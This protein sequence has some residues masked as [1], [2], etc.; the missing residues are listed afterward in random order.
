MAKRK[1]KKKRFFIITNLVIFITIL[2]IASYFVVEKNLSLKLKGSL[3]N[4]LTINNEYKDTGYNANL[5]GINLDKYVIIDSNLKNDKIGNYLITYK[6]KFLLWEKEVS[7]TIIV[8]DELKQENNKEDNNLQTD[9]ENVQIDA[10]TSKE[11][12]KNSNEA[13]NLA[14][15]SPYPAINGYENIEMGPKYVN[16]ILV[17]N[18]KYAIPKDFKSPDADIA[19]G[20]LKQLQAAALVDGFNIELLSGYRSYNRQKTIY[21]GK[22]A[23]RGYDSSDRYSARPGHSEH[24]TGL[25]FDVG[26][27]TYTYGETA[28][29]QWLNANCAKY[30]FII[31]YPEDKEDITGYGYEP[32]HIRYVGVEVATEIMEKGLTLEE[33]LGL[34]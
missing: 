5:F 22:V 17:V 23:S 30:G 34:V 12:P 14:T 13:S 27:I 24:Q 18:K 4:K 11:E 32:W 10:T 2:M 16:G 3:E 28:S 19:A 20:A 6:L 29:G 33:Y 9:K 8:E 7:R 31:R 21:E 26:S 25:A 15:S 1:Q